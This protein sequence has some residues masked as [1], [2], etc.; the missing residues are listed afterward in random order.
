VGNQ[1]FSNHNARFPSLTW[2]KLDNPVNHYEKDTVELLKETH[3]DADI[4]TL[5]S[6]LVHDTAQSHTKYNSKEYNGSD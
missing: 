5:R 4:N 2:S 6:S 1:L 3:D